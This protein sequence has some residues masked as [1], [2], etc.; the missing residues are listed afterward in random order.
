[1]GCLNR[2]VLAAIT[3]LLPVYLQAQACLPLKHL[4]LTSAYGNRVH[5]LTGRYAFH[6]GVDLRAR[7]DTIYAVLPGLVENIGF[8]P[9]LGIFVRLRHGELQ[10]VYGHL[11]QLFVM[12][13]DSVLSMTA[14]GVTGS[15]GRVTG[16]HLHFAVKF[17][18]HF[19]DPLAF[20]LA[21]IKNNLNNLIIK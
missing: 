20:L 8:D 18:G 3:L 6:A 19:I 13:G 1:M 10:T 7:D 5:P 15:T 9:L 12:Q 17:Q 14:L 21:I 11:S 4:Q 16:E 2:C